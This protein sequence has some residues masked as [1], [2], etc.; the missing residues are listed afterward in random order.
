MDTYNQASKRCSAFTIVELLVV[1][2]IIAALIAMLLP[3]LNKARDM[4]RTTQCLSN[5]R[6]IGL[7]LNTYAN[8]YRGTLPPCLIGFRADQGKVT[9]ITY[10]TSPGG[11]YASFDPGVPGNFYGGSWVELLA[12]TKSIPPTVHTPQYAW[13]TYWSA[14]GVGVFL[15]PN[16]GGGAFEYTTDPTKIEIRGYGL[17]NEFCGTYGAIPQRWTKASRLKPDKILVFDGYVGGVDDQLTGTTN[18][19]YLRHGGAKSLLS[20]DFRKVSAANYLYADWHAE[21]NRSNHVPDPHH[22]GSTLALR[23]KAKRLDVSGPWNQQLN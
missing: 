16:W 13:N 6:Q 10:K 2:A 18:S 11:T 17:N 7:A 8:S 22:T 23:E 9:A 5:L 1:I 20:P 14:C 15:C 12:L 19:V 21:M 3:A 4:A